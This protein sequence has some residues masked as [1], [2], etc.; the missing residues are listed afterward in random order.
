LTGPRAR[1]RRGRWHQLRWVAL[2]V[3]TALCV[4]VL[5][6]IGWQMRYACANTQRDL[7]V[8]ERQIEQGD[9]S[10][11]QLDAPD[12]ASEYLFRSCREGPFM[13]NIPRGIR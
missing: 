1:A 9:Q 5:S 8:A 6:L 13:P 4:V 10:R 7:L 11:Q 3:V 12:Q 2:L